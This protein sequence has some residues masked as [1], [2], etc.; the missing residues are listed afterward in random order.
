[1]S[2]TGFYIAAVLVVL[3][4]AAAVGLRGA[5]QSAVAGVAVAVSIGI[6]L[7]VGHEY[8][9]ALLE[10]VLLL[11]TVVTVVEMG[12][13]GAFG[14]QVRALP[15]NRWLPAAGLAVLALVVLDGTALAG[16]SGWHKAGIEKGLSSVLNHQAP[17]T[18]GLLLVVGVAAVLVALAI[19]RTDPDEA[20]HV[21]RRRAR[22]EREARMRR[23]REDRAA[24][25]AKRQAIGPGGG[26]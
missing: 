5:R 24:A 8:L 11:A 13:R 23:R 12:R 7:V 9:L 1:M 25:R 18:T 14:T 16:G 6:F 3:S 17:V 4:S 22:L 26:G 15:L 21:E 10:V 20:E 19:G 2:A